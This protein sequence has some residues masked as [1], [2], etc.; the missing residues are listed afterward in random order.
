MNKLASVADVHERITGEILLPWSSSLSARGIHFIYVPLYRFP[1]DQAMD[2]NG[3]EPNTVPRSAELKRAVY[4]PAVDIGGQGGAR[5][6]QPRRLG[7]I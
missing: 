1:L 2:L 6:R 3:S 7:W 4:T 5:S